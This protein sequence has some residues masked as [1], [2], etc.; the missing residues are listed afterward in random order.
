MPDTSPA[1]AVPLL[2]ALHLRK[3]FSVGSALSRAGRQTVQAVDDVSF[4]VWP[5][6]TLGL[7]GESGCGKSTLAR[8]LV[9]LHGITAGALRFEGRD[10][11][12]LGSAAL[13]PLR[14]RL[15]MVFQ[16]PSTS[17]NPRRRVGDLIAEPLRV[18]P[19][20]QGSRSAGEV[21][22]RV[23]ELAELVGLRPEQ[24]QRFPH[25]FSGGQRQRIGIAR[26]LALNPRLVVADE[27]VSA[28]DV[29]VQAQVINLLADL[30][31]RLGLTYL[32]IAH[33]LSVVRQVSSRTAVMYLG[34][35]VEIGPTDALY[36]QPAHPYTA[37]L[38]SSVP[39]PRVSGAA[40]R[41]RILLQGDPPSPLNPP[42][43]CR[44]HPRCPAATERCRTERPMLQGLSGGRQVACHFPLN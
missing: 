31:E 17:L 40:R 29:S 9:R 39:V 12:H 14:P 22:A 28:L 2:E 37:A 43:G 18:H 35:I 27:P 24:L 25:E 8:C 1:A 34:S 44:F 11:T 13:R 20:P 38:I 6:E 23:R 21:Q 16:D 30:Q 42:P 36:A 19:G 4:Q 32:F 7:V 26:A 33:D 10:I 3:Q 15:Q 5:G 41:P